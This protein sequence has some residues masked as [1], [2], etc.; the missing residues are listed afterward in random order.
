MSELTTILFPIYWS[1][2]TVVSVY[3][4]ARS[5]QTRTYHVMYLVLCY[6]SRII[7]DFTNVSMY[8]YLLRCVLDF[9]DIP[10]VMLFTKYTYHQHQKTRFPILFGFAMCLRIIVGILVI[11]YNFDIPATRALGG[12]ELAMYLVYLVC[13][14][15]LILIGYGW[16]VYSAWSALKESKKS[17]SVPDW[18]KFRNKWIAIA[19]T[20]YLVGPVPWF[21][22]PVD[23]SGIGSI[24]SGSPGAIL[25][26]FLVIPAYFSFIF[27]AI[28]W[29]TPRFIITRFGGTAVT[30]TSTHQEILS[31][32]STLG[33]NLDPALSEKILNHRGVMDLVNFLG[34]YLAKLIG[35]P[36][37]AVK[38]LILISIQS[39]FSD[40]AIY[41]FRLNQIMEVIN[42]T[43]KARL[44]ALN[45]P[46]VDGIV[47]AL[48]EKIVNEQSVLLMM[49]L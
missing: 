4:A 45:I 6:M 7:V 43:L 25:S 5:L 26:L 11:V 21:L 15:S 28:A 2:V 9:N 13:G 17:E 19:F 16:L 44:M 10:L 39:Q 31:E 33:K 42:G 18:F 32:I 38:G 1:I 29:I 20:L 49:A 48:S 27:N 30:H 22:F 12:I 8:K 24:A 41:I 47:T 34:D 14:A 37:N 35:K 3:L 40:D 46:D 36:S 23:G